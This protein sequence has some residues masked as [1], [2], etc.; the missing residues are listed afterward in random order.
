M[1]TPNERSI[2]IMLLNAEIMKLKMIYGSNNES[3][4][5]L[6]EIKDKLLEEDNKNEHS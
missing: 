6:N 4:S 2:L 3:L 1:F 5:T